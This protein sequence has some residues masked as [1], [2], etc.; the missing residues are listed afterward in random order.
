ML[1]ENLVNLFESSIIDNWQL[2]A[3]SNYTESS[4]NY[5]EV[6][7]KILWLHRL[8]EANE[9]NPG[10]KIALL[11]KNSVNW[12]I[13]YLA[14]VSY[15]AVIV[16]ILP[17]FKSE[18]VHH[19]INHSDSRMF[20][21]AD[22]LYEN[23]EDDRMSHLDVILSLFDFSI[24]YKP[25]KKEIKIPDKLSKIEKTEFRLPKVANDELA[26]IVYTSGTTGFSKG[27]MLAH[28]S[29]AANVMFAQKNMPLKAGDSLVSFMPLA[30][31]YGCAFEFL[32]PF[33]LGCHI[34]FLSKIPSPKIIVQA[35]QTVRP[36]LILSVPLIIEKIYRKQIKP[37]LNK[38]VTRMMLSLPGLD[39]VVKNKVRAKLMDVFGNNFHEIVIGGAALNKE[40]ESFLRDLKFPYT[41]GYGMTECGPLI[42][43]SGWTEI[44][45][46][47]V[48][49]SVD[50]L[51]VKIDSEDPQNTVGE[52]IVRGEN[53]MEGYYKNEQAT[54][55]AIDEDGW[56]RTG[57]LGVIDNEGFIYIR[58]RSKNMLLGP[59]GQNIYPEEVEAQLNNMPFVQESLIVDRNGK[60]VALVYPDYDTVD[61]D[62]LTESR[63]VEKMEENRKALNQETASFI[64]ITQ[65]ELVPE[66]FEKTPTKKIKRYMYTMGR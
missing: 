43:Y 41:V 13:V 31:S 54:S 37:A 8:Y 62:D 57:D 6:G 26:A 35:F 17:D 19:I 40:V 30:H 20:F 46:G 51:E 61:A 33:T 24:H 44:K 60:L 58:G 53:V 5:E 1:K 7:R 2:P 55:E 39:K 25:K 10:D 4:I 21:V 18:E 14:T 47:S 27:V 42:S 56:L 66:E 11:G 12:A 59:S 50:T 45:E 63:L 15:G 34:T 3:F 38:P 23:L 16:P 64:S 52:I 29:L 48:G 28:N 22:A 36:R 9:I 32:F 65:I 49:K